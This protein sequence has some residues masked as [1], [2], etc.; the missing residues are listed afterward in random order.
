MNIGNIVTG[1]LN[2]ILGLNKNLVE[3][4]LKICKICPLYS[5]RLGGLC[6][7]RLWLNVKTGDTSL[8]AKP[9]YNRG[10]GCRL[11]AKLTLPYEKCPVGK[12]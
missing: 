8:E 2:E 4:R 5:K 10:C 12:W 11:T 6:N 7:N 9:G 3:E 1:H